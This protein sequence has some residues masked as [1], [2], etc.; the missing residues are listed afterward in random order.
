VW[1]SDGHKTCSGEDG[2][3]FNCSLPVLVCA[4]DINLLGKYINAIATQN[5]VNPGKEVRVATN[6]VQAIGLNGKFLRF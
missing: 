4:V 6:A 2:L 5:L 1:C 3:E